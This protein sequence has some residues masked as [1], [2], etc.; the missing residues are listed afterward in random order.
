MHLPLSAKLLSICLLADLS[1][2][3]PSS[4]QVSFF[5]LSSLLSGLQVNG[6]FVS[7]GQKGEPGEV[8]HV[9]SLQQEP[10]G[11]VPEL[12]LLLVPNQVSVSG[13]GAPRTPRTCGG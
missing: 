10:S 6:L 12:R 1:S 9:S 4:F 11:L 3:L 7:Q 8:P 2:S 5:S 13:G